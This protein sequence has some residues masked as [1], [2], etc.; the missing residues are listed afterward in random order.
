VRQ[1]PYNILKFL[2]A[3]TPIFHQLE[4]KLAAFFPFCVFFSGSVFWL[5]HLI[6]S[7]SSLPGTS[8]FLFFFFIR[9]KGNLFMIGFIFLWLFPW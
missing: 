7:E 4:E 1:F 9:K 2:S 5:G 6:N 8:D 3:L